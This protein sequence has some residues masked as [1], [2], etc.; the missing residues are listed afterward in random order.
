[1]NRLRLRLASLQRSEWALS[2]LKS[3]SSKRNYHQLERL[4]YPIENGLGDF[5]PPEALKVVA[6]DYQAGLLQQLNEELQGMFR[7][8]CS[9]PSPHD[10]S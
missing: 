10:D 5:L 4:P 8:Q 1:M 6:V 7:S 2:R 9:D 3:R